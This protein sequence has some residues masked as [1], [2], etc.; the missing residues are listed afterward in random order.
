MS[1]KIIW[2]KIRNKTV[3]L[4]LVL[5]VPYILYCTIPSF[6]GMEILPDTYYSTKQSHNTGYYRIKVTAGTIYHL[7]V[8]L[9]T[10]TNLEPKTILY[11]NVFKL[12]GEIGSYVEFKAQHSGYYYVTVRNSEGGYFV[13]HSTET[14]HYSSTYNPNARDFYVNFWSLLMI[15][16]PIA[17]LVLGII[18]LIQKG[19]AAILEEERK[20]FVT[21]PMCGI[22]ARKGIEYCKTC[23]YTFKPP[24]DLDK[25]QQL[26]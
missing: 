11:N 24:Q 9:H 10:P 19:K 20:N 26:K 6:I 17:L 4:I 21:C 1:N 25:M 18:L 12:Y 14:T 23:G 3:V 7:S 15:I 5:T 16:I 8:N 13:I 2:N 22:T